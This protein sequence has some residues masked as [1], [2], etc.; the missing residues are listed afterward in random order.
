MSAFS[1]LRLERFPKSVTRF[2][3]KKRDNSKKPRATPVSL[4]SGMALGLLG[5]FLLPVTSL[6]SATAATIERLEVGRND[7]AVFAMNGRIAG[8]ETITLQREIAQL[9]PDMPVAIVLNSPGGNLS[10]SI[11]LGEF[12]YRAKIPTFVMGFGGY[13]L[14]ACSV[15]FLGGRDRA[16]GKPARFKMTE[17]S[18]G[19]HQFHQI[20]K[21]E[22]QK[23]T[24]KKA[25][26]EAQY[27][28]TRAT[29]FSLITYLKEIHEDISK[30]HLMLKAPTESMQM[31]SNEEA[32]A[33]GINIM[34]ED[35]PDFIAASNIQERVKA[36]S[37][38]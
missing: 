34:K 25:D 14:S 11:K 9:P 6:F 36:Q 20:R 18:L 17:G 30:L 37:S 19:F 16:T 28:Y 22:D 24:F 8:G 3:D 12:F 23:K 10:E 13:C 4:R 32:I 33:L 21:P 1:W 27:K 31:I 29:V 26:M 2:S 15:A 7:L 38:R 35:A 5:A